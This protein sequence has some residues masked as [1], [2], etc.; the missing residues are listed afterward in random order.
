MID[1][2]RFSFNEGYIFSDNDLKYRFKDW[3][4]G[5][6]NILFITGHSGGGKTTISRQLGK[7]Y[8]VQVESLDHFIWKPDRSILV[9][10]Y[11]ETTKKPMWKLHKGVDITDSK[12]SMHNIIEYINWLKTL[13]TR[14]IVEGTIIAQLYARGYENIFKDCAILVKGTSLVTSVFRH[15]KRYFDEKGSTQFFDYAKTY[16]T[17]YTDTEKSLKSLKTDL[18]VN[19]MRANPMERFSF[20]EGFFGDLKNKIMLGA[21]AA[22]LKTVTVYK[23]MDIDEKIEWGIYCPSE[24]MAFADY[25]LQYPIISKYYNENHYTLSSRVNTIK[26]SSR[27]YHNNAQKP[28]KALS[29]S[30]VTKSTQ[31]TIFFLP[32]DSNSRV[33]KTTIEKMANRI[34]IKFVVTDDTDTK[35]KKFHF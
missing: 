1:T 6:V 10:R 31:N 23:V 17:L 5:K 33:Y 12:V 19:E 30:H 20:N 2:D 18:S 11:Y 13:N 14:L 25:L 22:S 27:W 24:S 29:R 15:I 9:Q 3:K 7:K 32:V 16:Y 26:V 34:G 28:I 21:N 4:Q 8:N 35:S